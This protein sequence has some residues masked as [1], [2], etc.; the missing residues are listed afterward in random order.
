ML[1]VIRW[2]VEGVYRLFFNTGEDGKMAS[3]SATA[4][5]PAAI[6]EE[7]QTALPPTRN[8]GIP[9]GVF[10]SETSELAQPASVTENTTGLLSKP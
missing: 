9:I 2:L 1:L 10:K 4:E 7:S 8:D 6:K 5:L 3:E